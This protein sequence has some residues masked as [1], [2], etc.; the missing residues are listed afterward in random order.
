MDRPI[1]EPWEWRLSLDPVT[2]RNYFWFGQQLYAEARGRGG[3]LNWECRLFDRPFKASAVALGA[4]LMAKTQRDLYGEGLIPDDFNI[5]AAVLEIIQEDHLPEMIEE[6]VK[7]ELGAQRLRREI[8]RAK[9][10][11]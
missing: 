1:L 6:A 3:R 8:E 10:Q 7:L 4:G 5:T 11:P 2:N 9:Y